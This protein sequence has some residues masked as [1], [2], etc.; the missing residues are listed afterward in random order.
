[1]TTFIEKADINILFRKNSLM[2]GWQIDKTKI[3]LPLENHWLRTVQKQMITEL[4][5]KNKQ[6]NL[7][8]LDK[9]QLF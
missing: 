2:T 9:Q 6:T 8:T 5:V 1:M 4:P 7:V 3:K